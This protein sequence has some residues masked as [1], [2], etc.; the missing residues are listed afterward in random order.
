MKILLNER[1]IKEMYLLNEIPE[2][3]LLEEDVGQFID[4]V[5][6][7]IKNKVK[8]ISDAQSV[9]ENVFEKLKGVKT[10]TKKK[11]LVAV[12]SA[13]FSVF[14]AE[15]SVEQL[16][17]TAEQ[18]ALEQETQEMV[19]DIILDFQKQS[20]KQSKEETID[21]KG[22]FD[23][24]KDLLAFEESSND[25][26]EFKEAGDYKGKY[27]FSDIALEDI[28]IEVDDNEF[29]QN[30]EKEFPE[31]KQDEALVKWL[32]KNKSYLD[33]EINKY[34]GKTFDGTT[35]TKS[36][37]LAAAHLQGN[38]KVQKF[39]QTNG[40]YN[41]SDGMGTKLTEYLKKFSKFKIEEV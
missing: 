15:Q 40:E 6:S 41:P 37:I 18:S 28:G 5:K 33:D 10:G 17:Q 8:S 3:S 20:K 25:W 32:K 11:V 35:I 12:F 30:P 21:F 14:P 31:Q 2:A 1:Q 27:Q 7:V 26:T 24:F 16:K 36:G 39:F 9:L 13:L 23:D 34:A 4:K 38:N 22:D 19:E 29:K